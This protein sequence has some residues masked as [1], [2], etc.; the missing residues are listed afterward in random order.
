LSEGELMITQGIFHV[1]GFV[2]ALVTSLYIH[3]DQ[4]RDAYRNR[5]WLRFTNHFLLP[6]LVTVAHLVN[7]GLSFAASDDLEKIKMKKAQ[8][9]LIHLPALLHILNHGLRV[10]N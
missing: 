3:Q 7:I 6:I 10:I 9:L 5:Q 8:E 1:V 2:G 4:G